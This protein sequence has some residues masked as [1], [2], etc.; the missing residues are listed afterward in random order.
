MVRMIE[1]NRAYEANQK[2]I[3]S[4]DT[5]L[6]TATTLKRRR[7]QTRGLG[8]CFR[9]TG[10]SENGSILPAKNPPPL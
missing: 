4:G 9:E 1:V 10:I 8:F 3:Q 5:I 2:T 6:G 7:T